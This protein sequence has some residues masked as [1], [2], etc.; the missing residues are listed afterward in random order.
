MDIY[1]I[2]VRLVHI[3]AGVFWVGG[4][5]VFAGFL[6]PT[7]KA[8]VPEGPRFMQRLLS[9]PLAIA[10]TVAPP[11]N[12]LA[13]LLLYWHDSAGLSAI[14][15]T[16]ATGLV[17][18]VGG[19]FGISA[20]AVALSVIRPATLRLDSVSREIQSG[21]KPPTPEQLGRIDR[22]QARITLGAIWTAI[23]VSLALAAMATA[24][25]F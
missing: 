11:L 24:R 22:F 15:I 25:Y 13:R 10:M 4:I 9:G 19:L 17:F 7:A 3:L 18:T 12:V 20:L 2:A 1:M 8:L 5:V 16:T 6:Q 21:G 23:L 14:W